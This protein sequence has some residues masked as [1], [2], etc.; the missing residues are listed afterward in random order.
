M[1]EP[2]YVDELIAHMTSRMEQVVPFMLW[3]T[4]AS[5]AKRTHVLALQ[6]S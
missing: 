1:C 6:E 2:L 3:K 5:D 4:L